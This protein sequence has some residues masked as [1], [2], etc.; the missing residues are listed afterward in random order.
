MPKPSLVYQIAERLAP[1]I[2]KRVGVHPPHVQHLAADA[3]TSDAGFQS[4]VTGTEER[5]YEP[6]EC[7][8]LLDEEK[9]CWSCDAKQR[10]FLAAKGA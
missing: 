7:N 1:I 4:L 8:L 9:P 2:C 5:S 3:L 10:L 6:C